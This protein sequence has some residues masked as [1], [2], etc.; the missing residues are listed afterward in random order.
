MPPT[1]LFIPGPT[2]VRPDVLRQLSRPIIGHRS[3]EFGQL[4]QRLQSRL[5]DLFQTQD[6]VYISTSS[7]TGLWE[8]AVRNGVRTQCLNLVNGAFSERWRTATLANGK[9][10]VA[11]K[12]DWGRAIRPEQVEAVLKQHHVDAVALVHNET[13]TG[14]LNPLGEIAEVV[15]QY[16]EVLLM[17][18][19]VSSLGGVDVPVSDLGL[20]VCLTSSQKALALPPGMSLAS[21]SDRA[22]AR[23][24]EVENRGYYFDFLVFERY[25]TRN[26][27]P[28]TP[29]ISLLYALDYQL[30]RILEEGL[31]TRF[32]RHR[33]M[34][35]TV[36]AWAEERGF[37]L[38]AEEGYRSPTVTVVR[39]TRGIDIG[40][41]QAHLSGQGMTIADGYGPLK[42]ETFRIAHMGD[43]TLPEVQELLAAMDD[44]LH[45]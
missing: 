12:A 9:Q 19:A 4:F 34:A 44:F 38:F 21:V 22:L 1:R 18:D 29:P 39:N 27:T 43:L 6:R 42:G 40:A 23:A 25:Q 16:P 31:E 36:R 5:R 15:R 30:E 20:D 3:A 37:E 13:S 11:V 7:G 41:L 32:R 28:S 24:A 17:V 8:A 35:Q 45:R 14:V 33:L 26:Q 10:S 2:E